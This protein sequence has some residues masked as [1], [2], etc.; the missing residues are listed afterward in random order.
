MYLGAPLLICVCIICSHFSLCFLRDDTLQS[1]SN[2]EVNLFQLVTLS[3]KLKNSTYKFDVYFNIF[4]LLL[5]RIHKNLNGNPY[6][7]KKI[8]ITRIKI[9]L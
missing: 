3:T 8:F 1:T 5:H 6:T 9:F 2:N 7:L 4:W